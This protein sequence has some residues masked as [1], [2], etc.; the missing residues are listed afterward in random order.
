LAYLPFEDIEAA[1]LLSSIPEETRAVSW[2]LVLHDGMPIAGD[3][4]GGV[5]LLSELP[6]TQIFGY[7]LKTLR[8]STVVDALDRLVARQRGRLSR[9][10]PDVTAPRRYP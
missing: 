9:I 8:L 7:L 6:G 5:A 2:W 4:G 3:E 1:A 10:V